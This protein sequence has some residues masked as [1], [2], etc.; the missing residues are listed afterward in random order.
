MFTDGAII[1]GTWNRP[2]PAKPATLTDVNGQ[3]ILLT[4]GRT[5]VALP[6]QGAG[7]GAPGQDS[8]TVRP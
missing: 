1:P 5:W 8:L 7:A 3:P 2:D 4:P 6:Q